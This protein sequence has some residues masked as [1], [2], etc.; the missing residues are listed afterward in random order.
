M[1]SFIKNISGAVIIG[2]SIII[3]LNFKEFKDF[4]GSIIGEIIYVVSGQKAEVLE[5][6]KRHYNFIVKNILDKK[7]TF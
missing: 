1:F 5:A 2:I 7:N 4:S 6:R 3:G